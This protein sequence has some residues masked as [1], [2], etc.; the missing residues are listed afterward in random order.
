MI[1][2]LEFTCNIEPHE[3]NTTLNGFLIGSALYYFFMGNYVTGFDFII[4][5]FTFVPMLKNWV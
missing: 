2:T 1:R 4:L 3:Y 5:I